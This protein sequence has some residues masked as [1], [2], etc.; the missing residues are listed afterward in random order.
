M[1][2]REQFRE[3]GAHF[4]SRYYLTLA[5]M[6]PAEDAARAEG[7]LYEGRSGTRGAICSI[8]RSADRG[9]GRL[10]RRTPRR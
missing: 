10:Y 6:P 3:K 4:E 7:W 5:W 8:E 2:R 9:S 1:E